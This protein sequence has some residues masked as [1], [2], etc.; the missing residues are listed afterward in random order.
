MMASPATSTTSFSKPAQIHPLPSQHFYS[1]EY[2]GYVSPGSIPDAVHTMGGQRCINNA[3]KR[4][5]RNGGR[6]N[7]VDLNFRPNDAFA[8]PVSGDVISTNNLLL[9]V[10]KRRRK[11]LSDNE[12]LGDYTA[13]VVGLIPQTLRFRSI[14]IYLPV[15]WR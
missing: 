6:D 14:F 9:K 13:E 4:M 11:R 3:F 8:H 5:K 7:V 10:V 15:I 2:P 1:V 12:P